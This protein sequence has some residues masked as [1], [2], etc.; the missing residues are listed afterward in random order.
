DGFPVI[1]RVGIEPRN[2][3]EGDGLQSVDLRISRAFNFGERGRLQVIAEAFNVLN[4]LNIRFFNTVYGAPDFIPAG[5]PG[6]FVEGSPNP[7]YGTPRAIFN[8]RQIQ[9]AVRYSF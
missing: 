6:T 7:G 9:F 3:F 8:P 1:D 2:T 5:T 4:T